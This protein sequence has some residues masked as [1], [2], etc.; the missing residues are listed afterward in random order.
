MYIYNDLECRWQNSPSVCVET[1][2]KSLSSSPIGVNM[3]GSMDVGMGVDV[4][5][6]DNGGICVDVWMGCGGEL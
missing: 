5:N 3:N 4:V 6:V 2:S 1:S